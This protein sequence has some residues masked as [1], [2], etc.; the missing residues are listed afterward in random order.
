[1]LEK[2]M[3]GFSIIINLILSIFSGLGFSI[4]IH[5]PKINFSLLLQVENMQSVIL[6]LG[7]LTMFAL[8]IIITILAGVNE[9]I[10]PKLHSCL[11]IFYLALIVASAILYTTCYL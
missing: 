3:L 8:I 5:Q 9:L 11:F 7:S 6:F 1:M 2:I 4:F 10:K